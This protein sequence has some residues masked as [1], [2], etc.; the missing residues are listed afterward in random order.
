MVKIW[1]IIGYIPQRFTLWFTKF[2]MQK[3]PS[4]RKAKST[5]ALNEVFFSTVLIKLFEF[6]PLKR[7]LI[8]K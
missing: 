2:K 7:F 6:T 3:G 8:F 4:G 1:L 5:Y